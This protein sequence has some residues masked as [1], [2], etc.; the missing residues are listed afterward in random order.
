MKYYPHCIGHYLGMDVHDTSSM[1]YNQ[2]LQPGTIVTIEP[3]LYIPKDPN[4]NPKY[5]VTICSIIDN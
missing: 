4:F 1:S 3:G 5:V 2:K